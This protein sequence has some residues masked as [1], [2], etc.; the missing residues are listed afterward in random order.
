M[1]EDKEPIEPAVEG[2]LNL[3]RVFLASPSDLE[4]ERRASR[5]AVD[6]ANR[7]LASIGWFIELLGWED[8]LPGFGRPQEQIN[9]DVD[10]CDLFLGLLWRRW[11]EPTGEFDSGFEEEV[12]RARGRRKESDEPEIWIYFKKV[13]SDQRSDPGEQLRRV[14]AFRQQLIDEK[15]L[16]FQQFE[17][18]DEWQGRLRES[19]LRHVLQLNEQEREPG[20]S[21][22]RGGAAISSSP[23]DTTP[24]TTAAEESANPVPSELRA[25]LSDIATATEGD[26]RSFQQQAN[27]LTPV[28][29]ARLY[30]LGAAWVSELTGERL[31]NHAANLIF[32]HREEIETTPLENRLLARSMIMEGNR[33]VPG[34]YWLRHVPKDRLG[35]AIRTVARTDPQHTVRE[36]FLRFLAGNPG[37]DSG[38]ISDDELAALLSDDS[39][40]VVD[41]ALEYSARFGGIR[42]IEAVERLQPT[43]FFGVSDAEKAIQAILSREQPEKAV[44]RVLDGQIPTAETLAAFSSSL[45]GVNQELLTRLLDHPSGRMREEAAK[46]LARRSLLTESRA[47]TLLEDASPRVRAAALGH[48]ISIGKS[49]GLTAIHKL[50][51]DAEPRSLTILGSATESVDVEHLVEMHLETVGYEELESNANW[52]F[53]DGPIA[54]RVLAR[55]HFDR[56]GARIRSDLDDG[57]AAFREKSVAELR[58]SLGDER[59]KRFVALWSGSKVDFRNQQ[60]CEAALVGLA[61]N[62]DAQDA[63]LARPFLNETGSLRTLRA[64]VSV[65]ARYGGAEDVETLLAVAKA[66]FGETA[67]LAAESAVRFS[68]DRWALIGSCLDD[69]DSALV[70]AAIGSI[71]ADSTGVDVGDLERFLYSKNER[72]RNGVLEVFLGMQSDGEL[73]DLLNRYPEQPGIHYY[74]VIT[75]LDRTLYAPSVAT[76]D[77]SAI[78]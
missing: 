12:E 35:E 9:Q 41:A 8:R 15:E 42:V 1:L 21:L 3:L 29:R 71:Q 49:P 14:L 43:P 31:G 73:L 32:G 17:T 76:T 44:E 53:G 36:G 78:Q 70:E 19:L 69:G 34:W 68:Q 22:K 18:P 77:A 58:S 63:V 39:G 26:V 52:Y 50:F 56:W 66:S 75:G 72:I 51:K 55:L 57:F 62:G 74:D 20:V 64:A 47:Q 65:V 61:V 2:K 6:E 45:S 40:E 54:Y 67:Y 46:T 30:L 28:Q 25:L 48:L 37:I 27:H 13:D 10:A 4:S 33:Y 60:F 11:G 24:R 5:T 23:G 7:I 16:L 38:R 59:A